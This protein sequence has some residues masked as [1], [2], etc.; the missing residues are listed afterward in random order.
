L[1]TLLWAVAEA[2]AAVGTTMTAAAGLQVE[3]VGST[4]VLH[5]FFCL[6]FPQALLLGR[7]DLP[8]E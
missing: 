6:P 1:I 3:Q 8:V 2:A 4:L 5:Q 7:P